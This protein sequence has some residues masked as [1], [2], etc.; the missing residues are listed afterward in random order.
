MC[1]HLNTLIRGRAAIEEYCG[2]L[3]GDYNLDSVADDIDVMGGFDQISADLL[4]AILQIN[5]TT[6]SDY[7]RDRPNPY[8][9]GCVYFDSPKPENLFLLLEDPRQSERYGAGDP[10]FEA[11]ALNASG[12]VVHVYWANVADEEAYAEALETG[13]WAYVFDWQSVDFV[14]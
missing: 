4:T 14:R 2:E 11:K 10:E 5:D 9:G 8:Y 6:S 1:E 13:N 3:V 12:D 7:R